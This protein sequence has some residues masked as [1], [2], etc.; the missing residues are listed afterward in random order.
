MKCRHCGNELNEGDKFCPHCGVE[1]GPLK[2]PKCGVELNG[3]EKFCSSC[4][5]DLGDTLYDLKNA[6]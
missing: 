3:E 1:A 2:C 5:H 4:G 6:T